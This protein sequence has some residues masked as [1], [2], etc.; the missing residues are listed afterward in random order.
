MRVFSSLL[1]IAE[2]IAIFLERFTKVPKPLTDS[3]SSFGVH[4]V[5]CCPDHFTDPA[6]LELEE[7]YDPDYE[8]NSNYDFVKPTPPPMVTFF[9]ALYYHER[10]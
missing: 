10:H 5:I 2:S 9:S 1:F 7:E 8:Y 4:S 3:A 6:D